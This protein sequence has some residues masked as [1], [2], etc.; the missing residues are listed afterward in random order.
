MRHSPAFQD[1]GV[2]R[3]V[4]DAGDCLH[5]AQPPDH[6][7]K[8]KY[9][10]L[11]LDA[12]ISAEEMELASKSARRKNIDVEEALLNEFQVKLP[13]IGAALAKFFAYL[14]SRS[15]PSASSRIDLLK[16]LR[17][18]YVEQ[19]Q[20]LPIEDSKEGILI[21]ASIRS[22]SRVRAWSIMFSRRSKIVY[23]VTTVREFKP[24]GGSVLR[25]WRLR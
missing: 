15:R 8:T 22:R 19:N 2:T 7:V 1:E 23:R 25:R 20:W 9:D 10:Y 5:P 14:T 17:R 18:E 3:L 11:V 13:V 16:N 6:V 12:V 4:R 24:D 21:L